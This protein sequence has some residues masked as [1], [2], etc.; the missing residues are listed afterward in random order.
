MV[1]GI[2]FRSHRIVL[3]IILR[4]NFL[5]AEFFIQ[6]SFFLFFLLND[7]S[8]FMMANLPIFFNVLN[9]RS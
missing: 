4:I 2:N 6:S 7:L 8:Q 9:K 3:L 5:K 1:F